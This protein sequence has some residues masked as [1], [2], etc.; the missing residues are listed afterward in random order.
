MLSETYFK[1]QPNKN[2]QHMFIH[3]YETVLKIS[4]SDLTTQET[5]KYKSLKGKEK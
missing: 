4:P 3:L 5:L 1:N 2:I